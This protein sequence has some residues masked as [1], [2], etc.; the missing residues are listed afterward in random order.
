MGRYVGIVLY[1]GLI[2]DVMAFD[3]ETAAREW[4]AR[5]RLDFGLEETS[6]SIIWDTEFRLPLSVNS[7]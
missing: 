4:V 3:K 1:Q 7:G 2:E 5:R 6:D